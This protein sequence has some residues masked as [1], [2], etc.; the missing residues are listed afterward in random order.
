MAPST[1]D[2][3]RPTIE[4]SAPEPQQS[5]M[6]PAEPEVHV[7]TI[8]DDDYQLDTESPV[9]SITPYTDI[10][11]TEEIHTSQIDDSVIEELPLRREDR[12]KKSFMT[13]AG[14][15]TKNLQSK[16]SAGASNL[17]T[18]FKRTPKHRQRPAAQRSKPI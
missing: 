11:R 2:T 6:P 4:I 1:H 17:R 12:K 16:L 9:R 13:N 15:T 5:A 7:T 3:Q 10:S 8:E 14:E 18:K